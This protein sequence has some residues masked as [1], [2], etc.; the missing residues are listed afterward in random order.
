ME[1]LVKSACPKDSLG[2]MLVIATSIFLISNIQD[3]VS[4]A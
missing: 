2:E 3:Y 4:D 1:K